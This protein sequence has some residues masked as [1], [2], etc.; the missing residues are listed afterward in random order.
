MSSRDV[1]PPSEFLML[2]GRLG[3]LWLT[4][5]K[6]QVLLAAILGG[7]TWVVNAGIGLAWALPL[8]LLA[9]LL[10]TI[11][12]FG[13]LLAAIPA[14]IVALIKGSSVIS[15]Q[16]WAF[17]LIVAGIY[18][19]IQQLSSFILEPHILGKRLNLPPLVVLLSVL[20]GAALGNVVGAYL[21]VPLVASAREIILFVQ[22][23]LRER[24]R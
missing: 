1:S 15:V 13:P 7:L 20:A 3:D 10:G 11:P 24:R 21:A 12:S 22:E 6:G 23:R 2:L 19:L 18:L 8:G 9:G 4:Y 5:L 14:V 17:A 16:N